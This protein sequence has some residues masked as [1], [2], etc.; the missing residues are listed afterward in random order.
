MQY[1]HTHLHGWPL[2][3]SKQLHLIHDEQVHCLHSLALL[4]APAEH[5]PLLRC[6]KHQVVVCQQANICRAV[7]C[8]SSTSSTSS[9]FA[10]T[11][12]TV[13]QLRKLRMQQLEK[14]RMHGRALAYPRNISNLLHFD[15]IFWNIPTLHRHISV[16]ILKPSRLSSFSLQDT[17]Q[18][19]KTTPANTPQ[20][21]TP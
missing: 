4:P 16:A 19:F 12:Q 18:A 10:P 13:T 14:P 3:P 21:S 20:P 8:S 5:V 11:L 17:A 15:N 9:V 7:T 1:N 2:L 6:R